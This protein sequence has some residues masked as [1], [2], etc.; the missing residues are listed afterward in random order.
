[1]TNGTARGN[2]FRTTVICVD[3]YRDREF[4]GRLYNRHVEGAVTF[5]N[6]TQLLLQM[7]GLLDE[8]SF[9]QPFQ[10]KRSFG[11]AQCPE[12]ETPGAEARHG[13][14][15]T[16]AVKVLFRQN[17]SWQGSVLWLERGQELRFRSVLELLLLMDG[18]LAA[19][20][21]PGAP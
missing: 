21:R 11:S 18:A 12:R 4:C 17:A 8:M 15:A 6:L 16:F 10:A 9:P 20:T 14:A 19:G 3:S 1:M 2:E 7:D 5:D 13:D